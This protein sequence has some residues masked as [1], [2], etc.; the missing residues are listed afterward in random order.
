MRMRSLSWK[1]G[2]APL[3]SSLASCSGSNTPKACALL[4]IGPVNEGSCG[5]VHH[6]P[7]G[8]LGPL[9][10]RV[11]WGLAHQSMP[12]LKAARPGGAPHPP[13]HWKQQCRWPELCCM[14]PAWPGIQT[15]LRA[16]AAGGRGQRA[17]SRMPGPTHSEGCPKPDSHW[18]P[19]KPPTFL[20][21][22]GLFS[23]RRGSWHNL[24][25]SWQRVAG[26]FS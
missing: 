3:W 17:V 12:V 19:V 20:K 18:K 9:H 25:R 15:H 21:G 23:G 11:G 24:E 7:G 22:H 5:S 16:A 13:P 14:S 10:Q 1:P 8:S 4:Q 2:Q 6:S 26:W